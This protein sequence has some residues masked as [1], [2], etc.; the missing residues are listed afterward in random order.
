MRL[1]KCRCGGNLTVPPFYFFTRLDGE[2]DL[3][4]ALVEPPA[5]QM[6]APLVDWDSLRIEDN[7]DEEGRIEIVDDEV[8]CELLGFRADDEEADKARKAASKASSQQNA[9]TC[10]RTEEIDTTGAVIEVDDYLPGE[11][12][13]VHDPNRPNMDLGTVYS[14]MKEFRLAVR[15]FAINKEFELR[16]VKTNPERYIGGCKGGEDCP[17]HLVGRRQPD[18]CTVMVLT[19]ILRSI[20]F[21]PS[22]IL[23][24]PM[25]FALLY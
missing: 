20:N 16:V 1:D 15:Q 5:Q 3:S 23:R 8:M 9:D 10:Q 2:P 12:T 25:F 17:W 14:N 19:F 11:R 18:G 22:I 21:F 13:V 7:R 24:L 4:L 6:Q